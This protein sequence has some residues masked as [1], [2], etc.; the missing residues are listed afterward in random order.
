MLK[1]L[2]ILNFLLYVPANDLTEIAR[3]NKLKKEAKEAYNEKDF[4]K[5]ALSYKELV[6]DYKVTDDQVFL[7]LANAYFHLKDT[8]QAMGEYQKLTTSPNASVQSAAYQQMGVMAHQTQKLEEAL[9]MFKEAIKTNPS[10]EE[11][12][13]NYELVKKQLQEQEENKE[14]NPDQ[15]KKDQ[16]KQEQE[17]QQNKEEQQEGEGEKKEQEQEKENKENPEEEQQGEQQDQEQQAEEEKK[18]QMQEQQAER[19][20]EM[21]ISEEKAQQILEAMQNNEVQYIQQNKRKAQQKDDGKP[22]W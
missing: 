17:K 15:E 10:N 8:A 21:N 7:N 2:L 20:E 9:A 14:E 18:Q 1:A 3:M 11:A 16:E 13:Y 12:R 4:E 22:D 6:T 19:L 5:A